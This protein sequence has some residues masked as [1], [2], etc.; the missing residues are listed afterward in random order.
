M[1]EG[2]GQ[3][4]FAGAGPFLLR[5]DDDGDVPIYTQY[6]EHVCNTQMYLLTFAVMHQNVESLHITAYQVPVLP[7]LHAMS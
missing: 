1:G 4:G 6:R 2:I 7:T 3:T 5:E